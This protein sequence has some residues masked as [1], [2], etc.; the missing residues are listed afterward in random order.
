VLEALKG[1]EALG[2]TVLAPGL[3]IPH[4]T[5]PVPGIAPLLVARSRRGI[6]F[7]GVS[8]PVHA[9]FTLVRVPGGA[10][11]DLQT[12]AAIAQVGARPDFRARW[13]EAEGTDQ[14]RELLMGSLAAPV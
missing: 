2:S 1:R 10:G 6:S 3:A 7:P 14:L 9:V 13:R 4:V 11:S 12:L 5:A 8:D